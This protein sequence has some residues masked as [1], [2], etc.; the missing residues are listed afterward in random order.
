MK[1]SNFLY[2]RNLLLSLVLIALLPMLL[3]YFLVDSIPLWRWIHYPFHAVVESVGSFSAL[4]IAF[5]MITMIR[6]R[7]L[8]RYYIAIA[9]ALVSM[10]IL[11]GFHSFLHAGVSFVWLH[12]IAT[13]MGGLLFSALLLPEQWF[14]KARQFRLIF[15]VTITS[16]IIGTCSLLFPDDLPKMLID[17][18]FTLFAR[19]INILGGIGFLIGTSYFIHGYWL[20]NKNQSKNDVMTENMVFANHCLLFG[21]AGILFETS[22]LWDAGWWWWHMLRLTAYLVVLVYFLSLFRRNENRLR[23]NEI[24][25]NNFN[26]KL[27]QRVGQ[28]THELMIA[29]NSK[30]EFL[31]R[32]SH[33]LRT[34]LNAVLGYTQILQLDSWKNLNDEQ[35]FN[36]QEI[37][38]SGDH[39]LEMINEIL[40]IANLESGHFELKMTSVSLTPVIKEC[41][42][43]LKD[44]A[45][46]KNIKISL[47][48]C[49]SC[50]V[51]ADQSHL[52]KILLNLLSNAIKYNAA[53][54][55]VKIYCTNWEGYSRISVEDNG[56]GIPK[57]FLLK[58]FQPFERLVSAYD[59][60]EGIGI[61]LTYAKQ[62]IETMGGEI[63][64][65]SREGEGSTFW[66]TL[67]LDISNWE[68]KKATSSQI[69][70]KKTDE[71]NSLTN[72][73][74]LY[75]EDNS[76]NRRL[77]E[78]I[79][80]GY[81]EY[82]LKTAKNGLEGLE[83]VKKD[84]P[85][86]ILLDI[87][88]P[89]LDG[90][91]VLSQLRKNTLIKDIKIIAVTANAM[92]LDKE[93][94]QFAGFDD[95]LTK[96]LNIKEF[97]ERLAY[98]LKT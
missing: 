28:R 71:T 54:G 69:T 2:N 41:V 8:P 79:L 18:E 26:K 31:S 68:T 96:P 6:N 9:S 19:V 97:V 42:S 25:L 57:E 82:N 95:Y 65:D 63:G 77:V 43:E 58:I 24:K 30:S 48:V 14:T 88:L 23:I 78:K 5:L 66:V 17:G 74:L 86:L 45:D 29:N 52:K 50:S 32:M 61:G 10:G 76:S 98:H 94:G 75:I 3:G 92:S 91:E 83:L 12:S 85:D 55:T 70:N 4:I 22:V 46:D 35:K 90:F 67:K 40:T 21:V 64:V 59:G 7:H 73:N 72:Y 84:I 39:L 13:L 11:D 62:L 80:E 16:L 56:P 53:G 15:I 34:P 89:E 60:T 81:Q 37:M 20:A 49:D 36:I 1:L 33:E 93:K 51:N 44:L 38:T 87:N 27:E 47:E